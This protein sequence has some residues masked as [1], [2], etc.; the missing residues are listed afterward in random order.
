MAKNLVFLTG[1]RIGANASESLH[2]YRKMVSF[3]KNAD[4]SIITQ[5]EETFPEQAGCDNVVYLNASG[6]V[7]DDAKRVAEDADMFVVVGIKP[8]AYPSAELLSVTKPECSIAVINKGYLTLP[9]NFNRKH[10]LRMRDMN[11]GA[12]LTFLSMCSWLTNLFEE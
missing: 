1:E 8:N 12:G 6:A 3:G 4:V 11:I 10:I 2:L 5:S 9:K 7:F